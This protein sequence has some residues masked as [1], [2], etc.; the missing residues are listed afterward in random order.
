VDDYEGGNLDVLADAL[1]R[2]ADHALVLRATGELAKLRAEVPNLWFVIRDEQGQRLS[3]GRIPPEYLPAEA[4]LDRLSDAR[5]G[6]RH[7]SR[8]DAVVK[9]VRTEAGDVQI[10]T[11]T[12]GRMSLRRFAM[13]VSGGFLSVILPVLLL[14]TA[15]TAIV[16]PVVVRRTL[17]GLGRAATRAAEITFDRRGVQLPVSDV[18][19]EI[20]PLVDAVND[21][22][23][24]LDMGFERHQHFLAQ[25][26]HELRT[27]IAIL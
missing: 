27:P 8:P 2:D 20:G 22:L 26:A 23:R 17:A 19:V 15:A 25:A 16:T 12:E 21:A 5:L 14:M 9:W 10:L 6:A 13:G 11:G 18:P 1:A 3:E 4:M 24:R 7:G